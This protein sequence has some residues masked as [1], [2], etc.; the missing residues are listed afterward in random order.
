LDGIRR[1]AEFAREDG[2]TNAQ[3]AEAAD[4]TFAQPV[5]YAQWDERAAL[6]AA[7]VFEAREQRWPRAVDSG[8]ANALPSP[9]TAARLFGSWRGFVEAAKPRHL[10]AAA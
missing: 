7:R 2:Y 6:C 10:R 4:L 8:S 9:Q 1:F 3:I 5:P